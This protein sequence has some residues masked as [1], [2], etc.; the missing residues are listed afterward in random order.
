MKVRPCHLTPAD[1]RVMGMIAARC[2]KRGS[3]EISK[4]EMAR[5]MEYS[6]KTIDR[7]ISKL[8]REGY[9]ETEA[10]HDEAGGQM[11]NRYRLA[12]KAKKR[13][14]TTPGSR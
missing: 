3:A 4:A 1:E 8:R 11:A 2:L 9:I 12:R 10:V 13:Q 7:A 5:E 14:G 6:S